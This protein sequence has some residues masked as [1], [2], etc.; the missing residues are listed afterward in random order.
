MG[1]SWKKSPAKI[2]CSPPAGAE[3]SGRAAQPGSSCRGGLQCCSWC[4]SRFHPRCAP[5]TETCHGRVRGA[6]PSCNAHTHTCM[7]ARARTHTHTQLAH[8]P[9]DCA[10]QQW[11][12]G[13]GTGWPPPPPAQPSPPSG[14]TALAADAVQAAGG[15][16]GALVCSRDAGCVLL[17]ISWG[18]Y[19]CSA[20]RRWL[21]RHGCAMG[22]GLCTFTPLC[23]C[24]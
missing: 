5:C 14:R 16:P 3:L 23:A 1:G 12:P 19:P 8:A 17:S 11:H 22:G 24:V 4:G 9:R 21:E 2:S 7:Y 15:V 18:T 10:G 6:T 13:G 20:V